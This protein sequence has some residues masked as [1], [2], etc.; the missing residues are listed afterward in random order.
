M[1]GT[2]SSNA[3]SQSLSEEMECLFSRPPE[4]GSCS[5]SSPSEATSIL[6]TGGWRRDTPGIKWQ[7]MSGIP[8]SNGRSHSLSDE[9]ECLFLS[10]P[11]SSSSASEATS[12][13]SAGGWRRDTPG[14]KWQCIS[15]TPSLKGF[16]HSLSDEMEC[17]SLCAPAS[18]SSAS[19]ATSILSTGGWR[20]DTPGIKWQCISGKSS[21]KGRSHSLSEETECLSS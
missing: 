13:L 15:G 8:S 10:A 7:C 11:A 19:E 16:S 6:S 17:L 9:M 2:S 5:L 20:R 3:R 12:I 18:S 21:S 4:G 1:S 14:I